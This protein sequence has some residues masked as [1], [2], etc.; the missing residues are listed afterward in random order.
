MWSYAWQICMGL[1]H[2]HRRGVIH[3]DVKC[4]NLLLT[5]NFKTVKLGDMS[6]SRVLD[7]TSYIKTKQVIGTPLSMSPEVVK[8]EGY[9]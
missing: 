2:L 9:D 3:R 6:E 1:L 4:M 7:H 8:Q 5:N